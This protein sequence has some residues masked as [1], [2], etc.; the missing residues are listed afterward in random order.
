MPTTDYKTV[1]EYLAA[2]PEPARTTL[3][4]LRQSITAAV[5]AATEAISYQIPAFKLNGKG[6][7]HY[8]AFKNHCSLY[9]VTDGVRAACKGT[10]A[11]FK[12]VK[13]TLQFP[14]DKPLPDVL[15][16]RIVAA[17]IK[18]NQQAAKQKTS[19][20]TDDTIK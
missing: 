12:I 16:K 18:E 3:Q 11:D 6:L 8:A 2:V 15:V 4:A 10:E 13:S 20:R 14:L 7:I 1:D 17:R 9:P 19:L 5:S